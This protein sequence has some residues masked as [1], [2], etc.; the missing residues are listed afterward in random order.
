MFESLLYS[1]HLQIDRTHMR[2]TDERISV[3][4]GI[5]Y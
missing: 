2:A 5:S 1:F 4:N 3:K